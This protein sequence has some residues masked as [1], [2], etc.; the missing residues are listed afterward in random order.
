MK[1]LLAALAFAVLGPLT[2][3]AISIDEVNNNPER[4]K[5]LFENAD[6][7][8]YVDT[9]SVES[10]RYSPPFYTM[11]GDTYL[12]SYNRDFI[13]RVT[14]TVDYDYK[15]SG[16]S[17][18]Q[19][20]DTQNKQKIISKEQRQRQI[21]LEIMKNSGMIC[22]RTNIIGWHIDGTSPMKMKE[23]YNEPVTLKNWIYIPANY[24]FYQY[25]EQPFQLDFSNP[26]EPW[27]F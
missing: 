27:N 17:L 6:G 11:R 12:A 9:N 8:V 19:K 26:Q 14:L 15:Q 4:Y 21:I 24:L 2:S 13:A 5:K 20:V 7:I 3:L 1:K 18:A 16:D 23:A 25:Y 10:L 22:S